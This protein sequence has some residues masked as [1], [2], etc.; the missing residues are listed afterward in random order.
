MQ[1]YKNGQ[2]A[3]A[4]PKPVRAEAGGGVADIIIP[5]WV[6]V[7]PLVDLSVYGVNVRNYG[8]SRRINLA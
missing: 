8:H 7:V 4:Q 5:A 1:Q 3:P 6:W 2:A